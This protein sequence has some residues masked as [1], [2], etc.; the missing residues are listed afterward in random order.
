MDVS[1]R[2]RWFGV[3]LTAV[4]HLMPILRMSGAYLHL[5][6]FLKSSYRV[7]FNFT[8]TLWALIRRV[9]FYSSG[10]IFGCRKGGMKCL[11]SKFY[12]LGLFALETEMNVFGL[13]CGSLHIERLID[14]FTADTT[15]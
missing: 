14:L 10:L 13:G 4:F 2:V 1:P 11:F 7:N 6:I 9:S 12:I 15:L 5:P 8:F 3:R